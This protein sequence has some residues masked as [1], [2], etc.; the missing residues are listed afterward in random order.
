MGAWGP[1]IYQDDVTCDI[2]DDYVDRLKAGYTN[3]EATQETIDRNMDYIQD[4]DDEPLFWFALADTQWKYGRLLEE[5]KEEAIKHIKSGKNLEIWKQENEKQYKKRKIILEELEERLNSKQ[6]PEKKVPKLVSKKSHWDVG[7]ILLYQ[8][9]C[10]ELQESFKKNQHCLEVYERDYK[11]ITNSKWYN[12]Y[13]LL[14]V[15]AKTRS[16]K[17]S[18]PRE[19][20]DEQAVVSMYNW[21]GDKKPNLEEIKTKLKFNIDYFRKGKEWQGILSF[22]RRELKKLD[23]QVIKKDSEY[24]DPKDHIISGEG[25]T[26]YDVNN[27]D[28]HFIELLNYADKNEAL[29]NQ[30]QDT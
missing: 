17:G 15:V 6:P 3:I 2:K 16:N 29:I 8:I 9:K 28:Y 18:L 27:L 12:K 26:W 23:F 1:G 22:N 20:D 7:D 25:M 24:K 30:I 11:Y 21:V 13:I 10:Y 14:R 4:E 19:Y 5:V